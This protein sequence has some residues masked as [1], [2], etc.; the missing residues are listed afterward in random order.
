MRIARTLFVVAALSATGTHAASFDCKKALTPA[1]KIICT[2]TG[3]SALDDQMAALYGRVAAIVPRE[4][5]LAEQRAWVAERNHCT[6]NTCIVES[7]ERRIAQLNSSAP[8][9][10]TRESTEHDV[11]AGLTIGEPPGPTDSRQIIARRLFVSSIQSSD[12]DDWRRP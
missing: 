1:E 3:L 6:T 11:S 9:R 12:W 10:V 5:L 2:N 7:Y 8:V 4:Q